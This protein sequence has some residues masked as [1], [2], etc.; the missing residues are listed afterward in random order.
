MS[1]KDCFVY[2]SHIIICEE[3]KTVVLRAS[4]VVQTD[5]RRRSPYRFAVPEQIT[6]IQQHANRR[7]KHGSQREHSRS[8]AS[9]TLA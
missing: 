4:P 6:D 7:R 8:G 3:D 5:L 9:D 1:R 2:D